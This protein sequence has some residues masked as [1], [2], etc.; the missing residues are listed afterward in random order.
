MH[1]QVPEHICKSAELGRLFTFTLSENWE[2][3]I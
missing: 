1:S 2:D 3:K